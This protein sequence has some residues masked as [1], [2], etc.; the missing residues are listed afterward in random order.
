MRFRKK[1]DERANMEELLAIVKEM[2][3]LDDYYP[4]LGTP[5]KV[6][7]MMKNGNFSIEKR[8]WDFLIALGYAKISLY[9]EQNDANGQTV[10]LLC[11]RAEKALRY[12][13][14][15]MLDA[16]TPEVQKRYFAAAGGNLPRA[17]FINRHMPRSLKGKCPIFSWFEYEQLMYVLRRFQC[18]F[19]LSLSTSDDEDNE[20]WGVLSVREMRD[21]V[22]S[23]EN[24]PEEIL[25]ELSQDAAMIELKALDG[26]LKRALKKAESLASLGY[27]SAH[28]SV[29]L[30]ALEEIVRKLGVDVKF[31][32]G[33]TGRLQA[34]SELA[35]DSM[36][37]R[38][39]EKR[40]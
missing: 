23:M 14:K 32:E 4:E 40:S 7:Q 38:M 28:G 35:P 9:R 21:L 20:D 25:R 33:E 26:D 31:A 16:I 27:T 17:N 3:A 8:P 6:R 24:P 15:W 34:V 30:R 1:Y 36:L 29:E 2:A 12:P 22:A 11:D 13:M 18:S 10:S 37:K 19:C 5:S 39:F